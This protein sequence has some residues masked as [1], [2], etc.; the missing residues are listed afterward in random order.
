MAKKVIHFWVA[1]DQFGYEVY[2]EKPW[3]NGN[4]WDGHGLVTSFCPN[5]FRRFAFSL[6]TGQCVRMKRTRLKKGFKWEIV[7]D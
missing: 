5:E 6:R 1:R 4:T 7:K 3:K 2:E